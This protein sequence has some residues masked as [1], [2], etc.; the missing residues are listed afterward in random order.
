MR[1]PMC[2]L[3]RTATLAAAAVLLAAG[4]CSIQRFGPDH[5]VYCALGKSAEGHDIW[6][7]EPVLNGGWPAPFVFDRPGIS[8][9]RELAFPDDDFRLW[10]FIANAA[11]YMLL[12]LALGKL[13]THLRRRD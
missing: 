4:S 8:V 1:R 11:F 3:L 12:L 2:R 6:C 9:E 10:P 13:A 5:A 7:P